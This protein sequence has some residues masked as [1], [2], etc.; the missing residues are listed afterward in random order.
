MIEEDGG[1]KSPNELV[2]FV[3]GICFDLVNPRQVG[4]SVHGLYNDP[5]SAVE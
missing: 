3:L 4:V 2:K 5:S 1:V